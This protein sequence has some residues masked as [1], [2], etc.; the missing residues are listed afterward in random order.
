M[1]QL[2]KFFCLLAAVLMFLG[3]T[4]TSQV[5]QV[6]AKAMTKQQVNAKITALE[7]QIKTLK[8]QKKTEL[9]R[10]KK[11]K[12][13]ARYVF[14]EVV[15]G[16]PYILYDTLSNGYFWVNDS[17]Y[18]D[19][20]LVAAMGYVKLTGNY[21]TYNGITCAECNSVK[22]T[23]KSSSIQKKIDSKKKALK[24]Y[25]NSLKDKVTLENEKIKVGKTVKISKSWKYSGAYNTLTWKSSDKQIAT[26][27]KN[28]KVTA[29]KAGTVTIT[30]KASLSGITSK[31]KVTVV[32][33]QNV[34][35]S[36]EETGSEMFFGAY[37]YE[38][39]NENI[40]ASGITYITLY[41][42]QQ[43]GEDIGNISIESSDDG[44]ASFEEA[45]MVGDNEYELGFRIGRPGRAVI[46]AAAENGLT[47]QCTLDYIAEYNDPGV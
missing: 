15:C 28:G 1:N 21:R 47:A 26:V 32:E 40:N 7:Q 4:C 33:E 31:C 43:E 11:E 23:N 10:E 30:A 24:K 5:Y 46:T 38:T 44:I 41:V 36:Y 6:Q 39:R 35:P 42:Y 8:N 19:N 17:R 29:K 18:L 37:A 3:C 20:L 12:A 14:A 13:G 9:A 27:D 16:S 45:E 22:V 25:Q 34:N 2:K